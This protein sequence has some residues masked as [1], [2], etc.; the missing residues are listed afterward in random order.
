MVRLA[1]KSKTDEQVEGYFQK[2][3]RFKNVHD[4]LNAK[5]NVKNVLP[6]K[7]AERNRPK[8]N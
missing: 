3:L 4:K 7:F 6:K 8:K 5:R 1:D 2:T